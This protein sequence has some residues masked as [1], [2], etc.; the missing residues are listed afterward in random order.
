M[1]DGRAGSSIS[2]QND[3][4]H[5]LHT[6]DIQLEELF[7]VLSQCLLAFAGFLSGFPPVGAGGGRE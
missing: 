7:F 3:T 5:P 4:V 6:G 1:N 2:E